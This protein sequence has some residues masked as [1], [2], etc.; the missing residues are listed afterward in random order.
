[1]II[2]FVVSIM[3][4]MVK[5]FIDERRM[6][7]LASFFNKRETRNYKHSHI[8]YATCLWEDLKVGEII[9]VFNGEEVPADVLL[10]SA[11]SLVALIDES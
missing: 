6:K 5:E 8:N 4:Q 11:D 1:M 3:I 10:V 2:N 7:P 9:Q